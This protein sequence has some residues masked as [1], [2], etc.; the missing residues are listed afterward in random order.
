[1]ELRKRIEGLSP[2]RLTL[3]ALE[4]EA[5]VRDLESARTE[6]IAIVGLACRVPGDCDTPSRY[7]NLLNEGRDAVTEVP[8]DRFKIDDYFDADSDVPG[9]ISSRWGGFTKNIDRFDAPF[10]GIS[11]REAV[12]MDPQQ[13]MLLEVCWEALENAGQSPHELYGSPTGVYVGLSTGDYY[14]MLLS[15][16]QNAIDAYL[17][18]GSAHSVAAGRIAYVLGLQGPNFPVDTACSSSL[19]SVHLAVQGLR[20]GE[21]RM[22]LAGG[23][24]AVLSPDISIALT[25][26]RMF[27]PDGRCKAFDHRADGFVRS[28][29]CGIVV[30]K[31]LSDAL[32][33]GDNIRAIIRGSAVNQDGRSSGITAPNGA[34]QEAVIRQAVANA[35]VAPADIDYVEAHGT[36]TSLGD[37]IEAHALAA[38]LGAGRDQLASAG[39]GL[40]QDQHRAPGIGRRDCRPDQGCTLARAR[41]H[42]AAPALREIE[43]AHRL[44][45]RSSRDSG[46]RQRLEAGSQTATGRGQ[47]VRLQRHQCPRDRRGGAARNSARRSAAAARGPRSG[48]VGAQRGSTRHTGDALQRAPRSKT[49]PSWPTSATR[50]PPGAHTLRSAPC[51]WVRPASS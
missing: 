45:R 10:F 2:K 35:G 24:N 20:N 48:P 42:S 4:L 9:C 8:P 40:G 33:N 25:K 16:G 7:W 30:L 44:E 32:A 3:L 41:A 34:S 13:R 11:R 47:L 49:P 37:P 51:T 22:A 1:M 17:A 12:S 38:A 14:Q 19:L 23:A 31:R 15:R 21:C 39:G 50:P 43:S 36:G 18:T 28:E 26:S 27:A 46:A 29:G 5:K 6:P